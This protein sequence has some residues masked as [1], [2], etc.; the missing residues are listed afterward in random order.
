M[1]QFIFDVVCRPGQEMNVM[2]VYDIA[3]K[4]IAYTTAIPEVADVFCEWGS[5]YVLTT[6]KKVSV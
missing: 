6:D 5:L 4:F 1:R 2:T 3:N